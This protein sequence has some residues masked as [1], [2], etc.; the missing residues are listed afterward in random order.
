[1]SDN[2]RKELRDSIVEMCTNTLD[3][4]ENGFPLPEKDRSEVSDVVYNVKHYYKTME[5]SALKAIKAGI[6]NILIRIRN[7]TYFEKDGHMGVKNIYVRNNNEYYYFDNGKSVFLGNFCFS[8]DDAEKEFLNSIE[9]YREKVKDLGV[10]F[11]TKAIKRKK[12]Y[13]LAVNM[14]DPRIHFM[15]NISDFLVKDNRF[16]FFY[17]HKDPFIWDMINMNRIPIAIKDPLHNGYDCNN[18]TQIDM[19]KRRPY[20]QACGWRS[21]VKMYSSSARHIEDL[22]WHDIERVIKYAN[23][24][25]NMFNDDYKLSYPKVR[26]MEIVPSGATGYGFSCNFRLLN[27]S[28]QQSDFVPISI[29]FAYKEDKLIITNIEYTDSAK[30]YI[31]NIPGEIVYLEGTTESREAFGVYLYNN[32]EKPNSSEMIYKVNGSSIAR[33]YFKSSNFLE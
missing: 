24:N 2:Q 3:I 21:I 4:V 28:D 18:I 5:I 23:L 15:A 25:F 20:L 13:D 26:K 33:V 7:N 8:D 30:S 10:V 11:N 1:M 32:Y 31:Y 29:S 6:T 16:A 14:T 17:E 19:D 22:E 27:I 9:P 12:W